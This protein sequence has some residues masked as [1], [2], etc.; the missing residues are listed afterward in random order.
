ML[1]A[2]LAVAPAAA[3]GGFVRAKP[4]ETAASYV[5]KKPVKVWCAKTQTAWN[6]FMAARFDAAETH[7]WTPYAGA[8][9][10]YIDAEGCEILTD[11]KY[12]T[13]GRIGVAA[14]ILTHESIHMRGEADEG[15]TDCDAMHE[16]PGVAVRFF[17]IKAGKQLRALMAALWTWHR[18]LAPQYQS[19]C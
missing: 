13:L 4:L 14:E 18:T 2:V 5:A 17:G 1:V 11:A 7:G 16:V 9:Q 6:S 3:A 15:V 8:N 19:I 10:T 12:E